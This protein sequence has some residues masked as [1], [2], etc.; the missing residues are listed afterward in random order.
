MVQAVIVIYFMLM[1][2]VLFFN[3][4]KDLNI[5]EHQLIS[6]CFVDNILSINFC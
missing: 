6:N 1:Q 4:D 2:Q 5:I 3:L